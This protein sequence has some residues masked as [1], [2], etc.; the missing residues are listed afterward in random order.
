MAR[1]VG[2]DLGT[3]TSTVAVMYEGKPLPI[4][5]AANERIIPS[6]VSFVDATHAVVGTEA[7]AR[8]VLDPKTTV[9]SSKRLIGRK[10]FS[11]EV[12]KAQVIMPY[13]IVE[14]PN[15]SVL[16]RMHGKDYS[17]PEIGSFILRDLKNTAEAFLG[18]PVTQAVI[19]VP[20]YFNDGQRQATKDAGAIAGLDVLRIL[21]EPT[22][23]ALAFGYGKGL[24]Q[25]VVIYDLGG[26]TFDVSVLEIGADVFEVIST[27][28]D[29]YLGGDDFDDRLIDYFADTFF[30]QT[31]IDLR[32]DK[33][34][35]QKLKMEAERVKIALSTE[36]ET[37]A[38]IPA[39]ATDKSGQVKDLLIQ[40]SRNMFANI[41]YDLIQRTFKVCDEALQAARLTVSEIEGVI[42]VGGST[43]MPI[44]QDA[45]RNYY[46]KEPK[47]GVDPDLVVANGA[48]IQANSLAGGSSPQAN[49]SSSLLLDVTPQSLGV[50]TAGGLCDMLVARNSSIPTSTTRT[51][52]TSRDN[53]TSVKIQ[54]FQGESR[55]SAENEL[56]GEFT[57]GGLRPAPRGEVKIEVTFD[58]DSDGIV[59][60][61]AKD[62]VS[63]KEERIKITVSGGLSAE[64]LEKA[65]EQS[66]QVS[67]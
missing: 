61:S 36:L 45:V 55:N 19:T 44:I 6:V 31:K 4:P 53:Q 43:K 16:I 63:G 51:F 17:L 30:Q 32:K 38:N 26:G 15:D 20:A 24:Q 28:G 37:T 64:A 40:V 50:G 33:L 27:A 11:G 48:A 7:K 52:A 14:G 62:L 29:T 8:I 67:V 2:I 56:L 66:A 5:N 25:K 22:A 9:Y 60:V 54:V 34:A 47:I 18:E 35:L 65:R 13:E 12:K 49:A 58:I 42:L 39:I 41:T 1:V 3:S 23:A 21:N 46:L 10:F 57:L 59:S